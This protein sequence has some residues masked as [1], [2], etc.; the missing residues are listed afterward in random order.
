MGSGDC[1]RAVPD[2]FWMAADGL[3]MVKE[4]AAHLGE[5]RRFEEDDDAPAGFTAWARVPPALEQA[6]EMAAA[7]CPG[8]CIA[9]DHEEP[10]PLPEPEPEPEAMVD[11]GPAPAPSPLSFVGRVRR[12]L[13]RLLS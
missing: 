2:V 9:V 6:V 10:P 5:T 12:R 8:T 13:R 11:P 3:A 1:A 7:N 4:E